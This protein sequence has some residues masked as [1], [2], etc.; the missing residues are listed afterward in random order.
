[1]FPV[2]VASSRRTPDQKLEAIGVS[3][4]R[5]SSGITDRDALR[6][7][8][9]HSTRA[10]FGVDLTSAGQ[11]TSTARRTRAPIEAGAGRSSS[12]TRSGSPRRRR[13]GSR[14]DDGRG[15]RA[16]TCR[17]TSTATTTS[18]SPPRAR[19]GRPA[20][21]GYV[22]GTINGMGERAGN[23]N[24]GEVALALRRVLRSRRICGSTRSGPSPS[25]CASCPATGSS[26]GSR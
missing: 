23:A 16:R 14:R 11:R 21:R 26:V 22:Q 8:A 4:Q 12:S 10:F 18:A 5:C 2:S 19:R 25:R 6:G 9:R 17:S 7:G 24:L 3:R 1:M 20:G 13:R 15:S